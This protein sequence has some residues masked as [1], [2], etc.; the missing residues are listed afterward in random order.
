[1]RKVRI[2]LDNQKIF[3]GE[4]SSKKAG[5]GESQAILFVG[6][7]GMMGRETEGAGEE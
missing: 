5:D 7:V 4:L 3:E 1:M 6:G 2:W